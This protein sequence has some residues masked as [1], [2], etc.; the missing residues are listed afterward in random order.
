MNLKKRI[1]DSSVELGIDLIGFTDKLDYSHLMDMLKDR[2]DRDYETEFEECD[3]EKR[4]SP[5]L[6]LQSTKSIIVIGMNYYVHINKLDDRPSGRLSKSATGLDYHIVLTQKMEQLIE[7]IKKIT[8]VEYKIG[9]DTTP[10][11]DRELAKQSGIGWYGKNSLIINDKMG[12]FIFLGYI[13]T[14]LQ[15][16]SD[17]PI[18]EKCG[19]CN[20]CIRSCP[21]GAIK[22]DYKLN[23][24]R[25]ISYL[26]QT[27]RDIPYDLR[28]KM[29]DKVYGCDTCQIVCP[30]N[31]DTIDNANTAKNTDGLEFLDIREIFS[32]S[33]REFKQKYGDTAI[34]WRGK[35][36]IKRNCIIALGNSRD[37]SNLDLLQNGLED[38]SEMIRKYSMWAIL[39]IDLTLGIVMLNKHRL[40]EKDLSVIE[41]IRR[42][43]HHF[44]I[45]DH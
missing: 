24:K 21:V 7:E 45:Y 37:V 14:N 19:T 44:K 43:E 11:I 38:D 32:L 41:E 15:I 3:L 34:S 35:N 2:I 39:K 33:N 30:K 20:I 8:P 5:K 4:L 27:K 13:L 25:C 29:K 23:A 6:L 31:K 26:T 1:I 42:L 17:K 18:A 12:S 16:E 40:I 22:A 9:V 36:G 10:M 28:D